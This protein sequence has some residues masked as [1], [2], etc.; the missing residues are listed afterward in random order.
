MR[1]QLTAA[2]RKLS[3]MRRA[4][5]KQICQKTRYGLFLCQLSSQCGSFAFQR[6]A[7]SGLAIA[8]YRSRNAR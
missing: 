1:G 7:S 8:E 5:R 4:I 6:S 3:V 2:T